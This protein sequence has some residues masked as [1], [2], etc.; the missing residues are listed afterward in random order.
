MHALPLI[1][2]VR[3]SLR[4]SSEDSALILCLRDSLPA[5]IGV[6]VSMMWSCVISFNAAFSPCV[7]NLRKPGFKLYCARMYAITPSSSSDVVHMTQSTRCV[8]S[9][10]KGPDVV[11]VVAR[12]RSSFVILASLFASRTLLCARA[13]PSC[14]KVVRGATTRRG[15]IRGTGVRFTPG[16]LHSPAGLALIIEFIPRV[17]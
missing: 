3:F 17:I 12:S 1:S 7:P 14:R 11:V 15:E 8:T 9:S 5:S 16:I 10:T 2:P 4:K 6:H 13:I